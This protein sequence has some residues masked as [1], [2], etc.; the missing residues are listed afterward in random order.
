[1]STLQVKYISICSILKLNIC[2]F[3]SPKDIFLRKK[4]VDSI[5]MNQPNINHAFYNHNHF[6]AVCQ[7]HFKSDDIITR[8]G[9]KKLRKRRFPTVFNSVKIEPNDPLE[10]EHVDLSGHF[11]DEPSK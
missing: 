2:F 9:R 4:W 1:M 5:K 7:L 10:M 8:N 3:R 11:P 6:Y